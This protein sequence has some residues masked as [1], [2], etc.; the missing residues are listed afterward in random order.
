MRALEPLHLAAVCAGAA[1]WLTAGRDRGQDRARLL[2]AGGGVVRGEPAWSAPR[3][4]ALLR[5]RREWLCLP[6][7]MVL[8]VLGG[9]P[10]P[11]VAGAVAVPLLRVWLTA[12]E[13]ARRRERRAEEV[14]A[15]CGALSGELRAGLTPGR[16][17]VWA[18][19]STGGLGP[20]EAAVVAA[21]RFGG[22]VPHALRGAAGEPGA[23]GL[24]GV[25]ACWRVAVDSGAGLAEGL[26]RLEES[27]RAERDHHRDLRARLA[28]PRATAAL[29]AVLPVLGLALG[30]ALGAQPLSVLSYTPGG[31]LCLFAGVALE[32]SGLWWAVRIVR[33]AEDGGAR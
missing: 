22:D 20:G 3:L 26:D 27:L 31:W 14:I 32:A 7:G 30:T 8:A 16:A 2:L 1:A 18:A 6:A 29:L 23:E 9:S 33:R 28:G 19:G 13:R 24:V 11:L 4:S 25:A 10:L 21:A 17:L 12:Q 5:A 15:F